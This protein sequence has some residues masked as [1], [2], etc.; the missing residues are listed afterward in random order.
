MR[1]RIPSLRAALLLTLPL[2]CHRAPAPATVLPEDTEEPAFPQGLFFYEATALNQKLTGRIVIAD[3]MVLIEPDDDNCRHAPNASPARSRTRVESVTFF[4]DG[5][6]VTPAAMG[7]YGSAS[8]GV[9]LRRPTKDSRWGRITFAGTRNQC[10]RWGRTS[11]GNQVCAR[12]EY[13]PEYRWVFGR[14]HL[15]RGSLA[16]TDT[17][18]R[19]PG[20]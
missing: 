17:T 13:L 1:M 5:D 11:E 6:P 10:T 19:P 20:E 18:K 4:C 14:L 16:E 9:S 7:P 8:I 12:M 15:R 3:T 2:A